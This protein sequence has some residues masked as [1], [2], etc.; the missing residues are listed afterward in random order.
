MAAILKHLL[1]SCGV[2]LPVRAAVQARA[3]RFQCGPRSVHVRSSL[4]A[5]WTLLIR[6]R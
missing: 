4:D 3:A 2:A 6:S 1:A 5:A